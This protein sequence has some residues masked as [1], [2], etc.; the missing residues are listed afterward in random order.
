[1]YVQLGAKP[2]HD[3]HNPIGLLGDCHRRIRTFLG[4][5]LRVIG[6]VGDEELP[7]LYRDGLERALTYFRVAGPLH[8]LDEEDSLFPRLRILCPDHPILDDVSR[9]HDDHDRADGW[10]AEVERLGQIWLKDG[11]LDTDDRA[12]MAQNLA[13]LKELYE[14]HLELE[15]T[16]LFPLAAGV[17]SP[18]HLAQ[19]GDEMAD[20]RGL[21]RPI[22]S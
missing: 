7:P 19:M 15:D 14:A 21:P 4:A 17:L 8:T 11:V 18:E 1:M 12:L 3:F 2:E 6:E 22:S 13:S 16:K 5:L 20:R 10:H 9:L